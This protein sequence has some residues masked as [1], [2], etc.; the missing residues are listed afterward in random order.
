MTNPLAHL[1][2]FSKR[3]SDYW[4]E[5][6]RVY[7]TLSRA[8]YLQASRPFNPHA[9][10]EPLLQLMRC[11]DVSFPGGTTLHG[12]LNED[13][14]YIYDINPIVTTKYPWLVASAKFCVPVLT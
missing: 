4:S 9:K 11:H 3:T 7:L 13:R 10:N 14:R 6:A 1:L 8:G 2:N 12:R 5:S